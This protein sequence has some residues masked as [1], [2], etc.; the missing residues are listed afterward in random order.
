VNQDED[1]LNESKLDNRGLLILM[2]ERWRNMDVS[3]KESNALQS[4]LH[5]EFIDLKI[6]VERIKT[7]GRIYTSIIAFVASIAGAIITALILR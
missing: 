3:I 1:L 4:V 2:N 5:K 6:E 7:T